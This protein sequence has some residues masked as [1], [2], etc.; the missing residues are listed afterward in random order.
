MSFGYF[1]PRHTPN[2][3]DPPLPDVFW[4]LLTPP[5]PPTLV[6]RHCLMFFGIIG[7]RSHKYIFFATKV[8]SRQRRVCRDKT[9]L[10]SATNIIL[11]R[12][13]FCRDKHTFVVTNTCLSRQNMS[14]VTT[15]VSWS[16]QTILQRHIF[17]SWQN[18]KHTFCRDKRRVLL[19]QTR[20][21]HSKHAFVATKIILVAAP[22]NDIL[23]TSDPFTPST[24]PGI[25]WLLLT[26]PH[27]QH[28]RPLPGSYF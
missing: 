3:S 10:L 9:C 16:R 25:S 8:L 2:T 7:G 4:L 14:F 6:T 19:R 15:K 13:K 22:A 17:F 11:L 24:L 23:V 26:P 1:W 18:Y 12:Q 28:Q 5:H 21:C 20:L 27:P